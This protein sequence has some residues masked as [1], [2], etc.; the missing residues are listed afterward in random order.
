MIERGR[1]LLKK[2]HFKYVNI[3]LGECDVLAGVLNFFGDIIQI[4]PSVIRPQA[5]VESSCDDA[6]RW[7]WIVKRVGQMLSVSC[8]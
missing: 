5:G 6:H 1:F 4:V 7:C 3:Q 8:R 2:L